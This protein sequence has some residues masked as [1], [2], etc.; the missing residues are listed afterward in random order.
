MELKKLLA[1]I[2]YNDDQIEAISSKKKIYFQNDVDNI[3][4]KKETSLKEKFEKNFISKTDYDLLQ[5]EHNNLLKD[6]KTKA[7]K[8][9]FLK[10]G[11]NENYFNDYL[12]LNNQ[13]M[14]L[15]GEKLT[16]SVKQTQ[17]QNS[18]A[19]GQKQKEVPYFYRDNEQAPQ[20]EFDGQTI[21]GK[22]W[23]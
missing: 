20:S 19:F 23:V 6:I 8:D 11:G 12:K 17:N 14:E 18:W 15:E 13:L 2:G 5:S 7:I 22:K 16:Q 4:V 21:Y 10:N 1:D 9:E 3:V